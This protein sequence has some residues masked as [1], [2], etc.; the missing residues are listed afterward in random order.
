MHRV[1][2]V[3][4][5]GEDAYLTVVDVDDDGRDTVP[6]TGPARVSPVAAGDHGDALARSLQEWRR[7]IAE[8]APDVVALLLPESS[9]RTRKIHSQWAPRCRAETLVALAAGLAG[10]PVDVL[11][12]ATVRTGLGLGKLDAEAKTEPAQGLHWAQRALGLFAAR[13]LAARAASEGW[14]ART[15]GSTEGD[16]GG[17]A[18]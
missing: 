11:A 5:S 18:R 8:V 14:P 7:V 17:A 9:E 3:T 2:G 1:L 13:A 15:T 10:V 4:V 12:R 6:G 16:D